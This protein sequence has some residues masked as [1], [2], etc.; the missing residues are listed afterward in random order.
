MR[1]K[2]LAQI[3]LNRKQLSEIALHQPEHFSQLME[4]VKNP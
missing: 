4:K 3:K 1:L 2:T